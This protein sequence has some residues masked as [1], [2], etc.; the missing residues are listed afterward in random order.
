MFMSNPFLI[1]GLACLIAVLVGGGLNVVGIEIP[2]LKS[3]F[4]QIVLGR[5]GV[6]SEQ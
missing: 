3:I 1:L 5:Q 2:V 6:G 4:L